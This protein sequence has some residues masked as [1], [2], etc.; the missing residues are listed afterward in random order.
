MLGRLLKSWRVFQI[1]GKYGFINTKENF[2]VNPQFDYVGSFSEGLA[3]VKSR[4]QVGI[5]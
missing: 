5:H 3:D 1:G 2:V 4:R